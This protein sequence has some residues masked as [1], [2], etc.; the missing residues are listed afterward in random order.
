MTSN[1][2]TIYVKESL[3]ISAYNL[4]SQ[5]FYI[6]LNKRKLECFV[7]KK[8]KMKGHFSCVKTKLSRNKHSNSE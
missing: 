2:V 5:L 1:I 7:Q 3:N 4:N 8:K 6:Y